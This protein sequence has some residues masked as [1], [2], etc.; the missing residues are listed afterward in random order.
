LIADRV[1][2]IRRLRGRQQVQAEPLKPRRLFMNRRIRAL[3]IIASAALLS[4]L[5]VSSAFAG[6]H[7]DGASKVVGGL[8]RTI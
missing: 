6:G 8:V 5:S 1:Y 3:F 7:W 4:A 2:L